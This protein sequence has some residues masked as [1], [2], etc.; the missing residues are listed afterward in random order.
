MVRDARDEGSPPQPSIVALGTAVPETVITQDRV[1]DLFVAHAADD[2]RAARI[3][4]AVFDSA[5]IDSRRTVVPELGGR[6]TGPFVDRDT[7][8]IGVPSTAARNS[9]YAAA[10]PDLFAAAATEALAAAGVAPGAVTHVITVS[11]TGFF[12]PGPEFRLVTDLG[13]DP[14]AQRYHL[15]F[16]GCAAAIPALR[17]AAQFCTA[18][19]T[20][21]VLVVSAELC[22]LHIQASTH[23]DQLVSSAIFADGAAAAI[24]SAD[25]E[26]SRG[27]PYLEIGAFGTV[28]AS[29]GEA[30][31]RWTIADAGF[32]MTLTPE[33]PRI[34]GREVRAALSGHDIDADPPSRWAV[35]P[36]GRS[37]LDRVESALDLSDDALATSRA[38]LRR[39]GNMSSATIL[40]VLRDVLGA[41]DLTDGER[42]LAAAFGPGLTVESASL[43]VRMPAEPRS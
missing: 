17:M 36:G 32:D 16:Q 40:F 8:R 26:L 12:A 22:S 10:A 15:G 14:T 3:V 7:G 9:R 6:G 42:V 19:P 18:D 23:P 34:V 39:F 25:P 38:V 5:A 4:R 29:E 41:P 1:R 43:R 28:I 13:L 20:A 24:V 27:R 37:I 30:D 33:V 35:H 31:M 21:V 11:C 2:R